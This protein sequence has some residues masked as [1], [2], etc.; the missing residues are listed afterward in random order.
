MTGRALGTVF[1][2]AL[3]GWW[4]DNVP[5]LGASLS[6][7]TLFA[8][9]P[10]LVVAIAIAG[11]FFGAEAVRGEVVEQLRGLLGEEGARAVQAMLEGAAVERESGL[12][13]G[14]GLFT[15]FIGATGAFLELQTALNGIW[16][17]KPREGGHW[18]KELV[19]QRLI[20]FGLVIGVGFLLL[21]S[22]LVSAALAALN[23]YMG[24]TFPGLAELW[25]AAHLLFSFGV[26]TLLFAMVYRV[27]PDVQLAWRDVWVGAMVTAG[28]F[29][30]G[31]YVIGLYLGTSS[32]ASTYGAAGSVVVLLLWVYYSS[33]IVLLGAEFTREWVGMEGGKPRPMK[34]AKPDPEPEATGGGTAGQRGRGAG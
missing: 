31:K 14:L 11:F 32:L 15:F 21:V 33:Q 2:R 26:I 10:V 29:S 6:F 20:S 16:R 3:A 1:K 9:A 24:I 4:S 27:L 22:L 5:R 8:L 25:Q 23:R 30:I 18:L 17:V 34:H 19:M 28:L 7:Y 12:A 13:T